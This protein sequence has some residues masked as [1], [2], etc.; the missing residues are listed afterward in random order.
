MLSG[1]CLCLTRPFQWLSLFSHSTTWGKVY[2]AQ[3]PTEASTSIRQIDGRFNTFPNYCLQ[4]LFRTN[5]PQ[6][7]SQTRKHSPGKMILL[8]AWKGKPWQKKNRKYSLAGVSWPQT[9]LLFR[10]I[11]ARKHP[12]AS[13]PDTGLAILELAFN[14]RG[15]LQ[16]HFISSAQWLCFSVFSVSLVSLFHYCGFRWLILTAGHLFSILLSWVLQTWFLK[17]LSKTVEDGW[18]SNP[19]HGS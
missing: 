3:E 13:Q 11:R 8:G 2:S 6:N 1:A 14:E 4:M 10:G 16:E 19:S 17:G 12:K 5:N 9:L 15:W 18:A 7:P